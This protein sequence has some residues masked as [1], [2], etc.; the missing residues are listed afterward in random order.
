M[1][2][3]VVR[4]SKFR[5]VYGQALKREQCYDNI[6]VSK[7]SWDSTFCAVNPKFLAII[8][9]SAGGGAFIVLPHNKVGRIPADHPLVGGHKGPV[10]D[11]AWCPHNDNVIASGSEDCV[12]KVWQIPDGGLS[13]TLTDPVV[14]LVYHQRRV[15]LVLWHPTAQNVLLTAGSDNQI[16]IWNVGTGE[17][18][19]SLDCHPDL[20]YSACWNWSGSKL[21]TTC[22]DKKIRYT[23]SH[24]Q[25]SGT[26]APASCCCRWT[27][28]PTSSTRPAGTGP[29]PS[30][31]P[32][33]ATR[34]S[35]TPSATDSDLE[36]G[37]RRAAA[38]AGLPPRPHLLGLLELVRLQAA[39]HLPRQEDQVHHQ[40]QTAIWNVGTGELLLSLD[41]HPDLIYSACWNWSGSK[42]LTTCRDKKIRYTISHRQRSGTWAPASCCCRWTA[43]PTSSTRPAGT[44]PAPSCSPPAATRRSGTPSATDSDL[45]R[46]HR[47]AAAVAGLPPRP[48]LLGLLELVRLQAA[49]HLPRQEDQVHHQPQTAIWNVGTGELLLSLDCHPDLIYSA[50]WNWSGSKLL[51]TCRDKKIRYTISHRQRS[52]T[53]APAS[54]CC[55]WTATPTSSTRPAGT[56]PAPSCS[57]PAATRRSGTPSATDSD[58]ERGHRRAAAVAGLPP[59]PHLL[60][61][62]ELVRLQAAHHLPRQE[63][64]NHRPAQRRGGIRSHRARGQQGLKGYIPQARP[65]IHHWFQPNVRAS[66]HAAHARRVIGT[67]RDGGDRYKQRSDVPALRP[68]YQPHLPLRQGRLRHPLLRGYTRAP[69]RPLHQHLPNARPTARY[70]YDAEE[71]VRRGHV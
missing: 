16:A 62:L 44:G 60:G 52:G 25:R 2:F 9:E 32:P 13:R 70:R 18:L 1:S 66:V 4:S 56:G 48:H 35:G 5:H 64:Q 57:P 45:E 69:I 29:A 28:T 51:T 65:R 22:R 71:R 68:R 41:C 31:S 43:T 6:R 38:V 33:A 40:P 59:R 46:G 58:L 55:R 23:I 15:G 42:L 21:L 53:W 8:V 49:H 27:A 24:R 20:I 19:L 3:R 30:C 14:D 7:S 47:R 34:R 17:V 12:V 10:L 50:C 36:R 39:H 26:W 61:L 54:C 63:D 67:D 11:I 37:H